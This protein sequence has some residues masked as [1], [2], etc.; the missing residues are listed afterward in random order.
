M[1]PNHL[2]KNAS[3][4]AATV[5][6]AAGDAWSSGTHVAR[7]LASTAAERAVDVGGTLGSAA[8]AVVHQAPD[9]PD[10]VAGL[11]G[12]ARRRWRP[13][14]ARR[15]NA[16][17]FVGVAIVAIAAA[18]WW[19]RRPTAVDQRADATPSPVDDHSPRAANAA[20]M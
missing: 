7:D 4:L 10:R 13:P 12:T 8:S 20:A 9:V 3:G 6:D 1:S 16:W 11:V 2:V 18:A 15:T 5:G 19:A 17:W 14:P